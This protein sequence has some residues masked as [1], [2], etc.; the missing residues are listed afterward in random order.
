MRDMDTQNSY[1]HEKYIT[2]CISPRMH[3]KCLLLNVP[4][5]TWP[6]EKLPTTLRQNTQSVNHSSSNSDMFATGLH[7]TAVTLHLTSS[8][9]M[10]KAVQDLIDL[11]TV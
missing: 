7:A 8:Y 11:L 5:A 1:L 6:D 4:A 3:N 2:S 10:C 9:Q